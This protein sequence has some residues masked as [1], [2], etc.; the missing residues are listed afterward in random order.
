MSAA[1]V[2][3]PRGVSGAAGAVQALRRARGR[4]RRLVVRLGS[5]SP[6]RAI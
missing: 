2:A 6:P 5:P 3:L 4:G 1:R